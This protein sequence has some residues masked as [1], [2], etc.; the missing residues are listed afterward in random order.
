MRIAIVDD[1]AEE[2]NQLYT[3]VGDYIQ[4]HQLKAEIKQYQ[5]G[6]DFL[7][8]QQVKDFEI[9]FLDIYMDGITGMEVADQLRQRQSKALIIF[10]TTSDQHAIQSYE[11]E[12]F[13]YLLKP[14]KEEKFI[15]VLDKA[16][17]QCSVRPHYIRVKENKIWRN[18]LLDDIV[19]L[20]YYNHYT[21]IHT[22]SERIKTYGSFKEIE[23]LLEVHDQ[24]LLCYRNVMINMR[25]VRSV[26][27]SVFTMKTDDILP[28]NRKNKQ[29]IRQRYADFVFE[30]VAQGEM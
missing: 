23:T 21:Y 7:E 12:A 6:E 17:C 13:Y 10:C 16:V 1:I 3:L 27:L 18:V 4:Q 8:N 5:N 28:I 11:V 9:V 20:D 2:R 30:Q 25:H 29:E 19:Y 22:T 26:D 24:F 15:R 14:Y